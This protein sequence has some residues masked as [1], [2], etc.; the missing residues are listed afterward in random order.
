[1]QTP[2]GPAGAFAPGENLSRSKDKDRIA[3]HH[4]DLV[5]GLEAESLERRIEIPI[6]RQDGKA[7][8]KS[9][10]A[11]DAVGARALALLQ[12]SAPANHDA[13]FVV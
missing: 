2:I 3:P 7:P 8:I 13:P 12:N 11:V 10:M 5:G 6:I 1:M 4:L 9:E